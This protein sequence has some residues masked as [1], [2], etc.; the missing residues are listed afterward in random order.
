MSHMVILAESEYTPDGS[1]P[2]SHVV[3]FFEDVLRNGPGDN[4]KPRPLRKAASAPKSFIATPLSLDAPLSSHRWACVQQTIWTTLIG[5]LWYS[6]E[7]A[8]RKLWR[9]AAEFESARK[10][11]LGL[12][13]TK[14]GDGAATISRDFDHEVP[15]K[16]KVIF[17]E[18]VHRH[19]ANFAFEVTSDR[20]YMCPECG[21]H[22]MELDALRWQLEVKKNLTGSTSQ[23]MCIS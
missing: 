2:R 7:F 23:W 10:Q 19:L 21:K 12:K 9:N 16:L 17:I 1:W 5:Y 4:G 3:T 20:R 22:V 8:Y 11:T 6:Q 18:Y 13:I 15:D 14:T